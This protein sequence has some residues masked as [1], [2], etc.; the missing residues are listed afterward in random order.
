MLVR[1]VPKNIRRELTPLAET[2]ESVQISVESMALSTGSPGPGSLVAAVAATLSKISG[3]MVA[4]DMFDSAVLHDY[5]KMNFI[6]TDEAGEVRDVDTSLAAIKARQVGAAR[7]SVAAAAPIEERRGITEWDFGDLPEV[8]KSTDRAL[9]VLAYPTLLDLGDS[10]ALRVVT[11]AAVQARAMHGGVRRLLL[12][13]AAPSRKSVE[14][15]LTNAGRLAFASSEI[16]IGVLAND[17]IACAV[18]ELLLM[19]ESLPWTASDFE[20]LRAHVQ[21]A[22]PALARTALAKAAPAVAAASRVQATRATMRAAAQQLSVNDANQHLGRLVRPGVVLATGGEHL[23]EI[24]RYVTAIAYRLDHL[25]GEIERDRRRM[26]ELLP[27]EQRYAALIDRLPPAGVT[28]EVRAL[29]WQLEELRVSVFAQPV[30]VVGQV[31]LKRV[32]RTLAD[33]NA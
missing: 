24:E 14:G 19:H 10:V 21:Q 15:L 3:L 18:D 32:G 13:T 11:S 1:S 20:T 9:D 5:L 7:A 26:A 30:G 33:L 12:L 29:A 6:V 25:A 22:A 31:S 28:A 17:C 8:V 27:L 23:G 16:S 2:I 4:P